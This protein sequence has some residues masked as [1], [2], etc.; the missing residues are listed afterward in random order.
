MRGPLPQLQILNTT[1]GDEST[2]KMSSCDWLLRPHEGIAAQKWYTGPCMMHCAGCYFFVSRVGGVDYYVLAARF[3]IM[4]LNMTCLCSG[5]LQLVSCGS[6]CWCAG[7][8]HCTY[9]R[10]EFL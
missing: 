8:L 2:I 1:E 7:A 9:T 10:Y 4:L 6:M 3:T 5:C